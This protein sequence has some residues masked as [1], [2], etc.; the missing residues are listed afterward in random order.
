M[1]SKKTRY[2]LAAGLGLLLV[3]GLGWWQLRQPA[4]TAGAAAEAGGRAGPPQG[5]GPQSKGPGGGAQRPATVEVAKVESVALTDEAQAVGSLRSRQGVVLRPEVGGRI[6][7]INFRDGQ[8]V[9]RGQLL[10]QFDDRIQQAQRQ[11]A[12]AE[13]AIA[14]ANHGRNR[15]LIAQS[16]ASQRSLDESVANLEVARAK[17]ALAQATVARLRIVAPFDGIVGLRN[18]SV[19]DYLKDGADI[20]N[21]EDIDTV[22]VDYR[23][24]E[25]YLSRLR[26]GQKVQVELDAL[27]G[28]RFQAHVQAIDPLIDAAGRSVG[29]RASLSN[30][31]LQLRPGMFARVTT[32]FETRAQ[33]LVVPEEALVPLGASQ[34]VY[35]LQSGA[36]KEG[37]VS[38]RVEVRLGL[39][40]RGR[41]EIVSGL[42]AGET[43]VTAGQHRLQRDGTPVKV[44]DLDKP[45]SR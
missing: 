44:L 30:T 31:G 16:F 41:V 12:Q 18:V 38:Q 11:Q 13:L 2:A 1:V 39:R 25:R 27:P 28:R 22:F 24:P 43:V 26:T 42:K 40:Q 19:G 32:Q 35:R 8:R 36:D 33:A 23:L 10:V 15:E 17:L 3:G 14:E 4:V 21:I 7:R 9:Q 34:F 45:A 29:V 6:V 5:R 37:L 20:V